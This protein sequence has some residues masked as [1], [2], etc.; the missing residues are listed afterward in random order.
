[1]E[2][3]KDHKIIQVGVEG[4]EKLVEDFRKG[5]SPKELLELLNEVDVFIA[6]D[7]F[8]PHMAHH[9]GIRGIVIWGKS[10]PMIFGYPENL[11]LLEHRSL[12][13]KDQFNSWESC[14]YDPDVFVS[15]YIVIDNVL[16]FFKTTNI[17]VAP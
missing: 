3:L 13:R 6:V 11:N 14:K 5:L 12:L 15:S 10:D 4:E 17:P 7:N 16:S 2:L 1:M 8:L 9:Y